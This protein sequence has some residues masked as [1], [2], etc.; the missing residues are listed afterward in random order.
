MDISEPIGGEYICH[1]PEFDIILDEPHH[2]QVG[3]F[4]P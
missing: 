4:I 2:N 1:N 3:T